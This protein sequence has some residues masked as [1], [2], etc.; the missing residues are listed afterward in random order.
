[1]SYQIITKMAYNAQTK[2]IETWQ[3][4]NNVWPKTA[5][6][7]VMDVK[8]D[9]QMFDFIKLVAD[10][11]WQGRK[12]RKEFNTLLHNILNWSCHHIYTNLKASP[13]RNI[14]PFA[15]NTKQLLKASAVRSLHGSNNWPRLSDPNR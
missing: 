15:E 14:V 9:K 11:S 5:H 4:S 10:S 8:T 6:F 7:Y 1:M 2:Q 3:H 12:W 13:G